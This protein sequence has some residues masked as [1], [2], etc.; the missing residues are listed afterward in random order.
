MPLHIR[1]DKTKNKYFIQWGNQKKYY[2]NTKS[3]RSFKIAYNKALA[4]SRAI[5]ANLK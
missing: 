4:Q 2:F 5:Y 3:E 1:F